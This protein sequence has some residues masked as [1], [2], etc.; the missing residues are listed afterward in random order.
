MGGQLPCCPCSDALVTSFA[1]LVASRRV[2]AHAEPHKNEEEEPVTLLQDA[3]PKLLQDDGMAFDE[4]YQPCLSAPAVDFDQVVEC[5]DQVQKDLPRTFPREDVVKQYAARIAYVLRSFETDNPD[6]GYCQGMNCVAAV[7]V[8]HLPDDPLAASE[9][10]GAFIASLRG[11]WLPGLPLFFSTAAAFEI[12]GGQYAPELCEH[13]RSCGISSD[14]FA[15]GVLLAEWLS[16]FSRWL[17]FPELWAVFEFLEEEV[18]PGLLGLTVALL[19]AHA[20]ALLE[21]SDFTMLF[22]RLRDLACQPE[23]PGMEELL[24]R[25]R[26]L[27]PCARA[28]ISAVSAAA[29]NIENASRSDDFQFPVARSGSRLVYMADEQEMEVVVTDDNVSEFSERVAQITIA[30]TTRRSQAE[31]AE[32]EHLDAIRE[33]S[34]SEESSAVSARCHGSLP[35]CVCRQRSSGSRG[36]APFERPFVTPQMSFSV[37]RGRNRPGSGS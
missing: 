13:L 36:R 20:P 30:S 23:Q 7:V 9:R 26:W 18:L 4:S 8:T 6:V 27:L 12:L 31:Q 19:Q 11:L 32:A 14:L 29:A 5:H 24:Q 28:A 2:G 22:A 15:T 35:F 1:V 33:T 16:L 21:V 17:L 25:A 3:P 34:D 37:K 10:F